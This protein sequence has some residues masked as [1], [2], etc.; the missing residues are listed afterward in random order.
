MAQGGGTHTGLPRS[1]LQAPIP[2]LTSQAHPPG[3]RRG[4]TRSLWLLG[5]GGDTLRD[6][7]RPSGLIS[8]V[9]EAARGR[10]KGPVS[11]DGKVSL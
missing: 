9:L 3:G 8:P 6:V 4:W 5:M 1:H 7:P 11:K 10:Q 2:A